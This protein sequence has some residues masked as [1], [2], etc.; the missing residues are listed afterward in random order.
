MLVIEIAPD[1]DRRRRRRARLDGPPH[2]ATSSTYPRLLRSA[3]FTRVERIDLTADYRDTAVAWRRERDRHGD[4]YRAAVGA[5]VDD[6]QARRGSLALR[7]IDTGLLCRC[8]YIAEL[9]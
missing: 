9:P 5:E 1:L 4:A 6:E 7:A 8:L 2:V 3:G